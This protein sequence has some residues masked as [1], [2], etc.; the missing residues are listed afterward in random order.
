MKKYI[1][2][3]SCLI[4]LQL[5]AQKKPLDHSV[6]DGWQSIADRAISN[7]GKFVVYAVNPQ[8][9][10]AVLYVKSVTGN[11]VKEIARGYGPVLTEDS[12]F[13][14]CRVKP[15]F[16]ETRDAKIK[17]KK[18]ED[19]PKDTLVI[20]ELGK[21]TYTKVPRL[22]SFKVPD[23]SGNWLAYLLD[24]PLPE[25]N[26]NRAEPDS[27]TRMTA[28]IHMAD[29]LVHVADSIKAKATEIQEKGFAAT[30]KPEKQLP[31]AA[32]KTPEDP[33]EEGTELVLKNLATGEEQ[34][35]KLVSEFYF[36]KKG[37]SLVYET[38]K[39]TGDATVKATVVKIDLKNNKSNTIFKG[40]NDAKGY[41][42]DEAGT[43]LAFVAERDSVAKALQK[44]Y[45][46]Y[47]FKREKSI[48][49]K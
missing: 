8:E 16:K 40:F 43:Q 4:S 37:T 1:F 42:M 48:C 14:I 27:A 41:R 36:N 29:S 47:Y 35:F 25:T 15:T 31:P 34:K 2:L 30:R 9:G 13:L 3:F 44:F 12:R 26:R 5:F 32:P 21:D 22:K 23:D 11:Y 38:T 18:A 24:K 17:K 20:L 46:L 6:Y 45:K 7:D 19:M 49:T 39:K 10:D 33:I 28:M